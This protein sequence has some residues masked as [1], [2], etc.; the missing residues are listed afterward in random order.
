MLL[1]A[2]SWSST[3]W[4]HLGKG[5]QLVVRASAGHFGNEHALALDDDVLVHAML[6]ELGE[7]MAVRREPSE[8]RISRWPSAFPQYTPGHNDRIDA[9][10]A[11]LADEAP[12]VVVTGAAYRGIGIP[13]CV[14]A[15]NNAARAALR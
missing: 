11:L 9:L 13:A 1:T 8:V 7:T 15:A 6:D 14:G 10:E 4:A 3:K 12:G 5:A 2:C